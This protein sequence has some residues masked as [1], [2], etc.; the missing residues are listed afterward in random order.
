MDGL[1]DSP[2]H[3]LIHFTIYRLTDSPLSCDLLTTWSFYKCSHEG[4]QFHDLPNVWLVNHYSVTQVTTYWLRIKKRAFV[5]WKCTIDFVMNIHLQLIIIMESHIQPIIQLVN[6]EIVESMESA[7]SCLDLASWKWFCRR[8]WSTG[9]YFPPLIV[10]LHTVYAEIIFNI[11]KKDRFCES[12]S[13]I[14]QYY[15]LWLVPHYNDQ[16]IQQSV[17]CG[18]RIL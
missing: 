8:S 5:S 3:G 4:F 1:T 6:L 12:L 10:C 7:E 14:E 17:N 13:N 15:I 11:M 2:I 16:P 9:L 18:I